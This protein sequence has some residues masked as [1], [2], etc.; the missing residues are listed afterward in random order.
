[1]ESRQGRLLAEITRRVVVGTEAVV[2][3]VIAVT[4]GGTAINTATSSA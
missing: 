1:M 2:T 4:R 3:R